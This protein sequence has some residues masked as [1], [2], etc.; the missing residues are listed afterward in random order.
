MGAESPALGRCTRG[1]AN[2]APAAAAVLAEPVAKATATAA[3]SLACCGTRTG[4]GW[5]GWAPGGGQADV[6]APVLC[7]FRALPLAGGGSTS[8]LGGG[9]GA[10]CRVG[11]EAPG[12][13]DG[14][15]GGGAGCGAEGEARGG[16][17]G[18]RAGWVGMEDSK[19]PMPS[20]LIKMGGAKFR[21]GEAALR[22]ALLGTQASRVSKDGKVS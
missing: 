16:G 18:A 21:G 17:G 1:R 19:W 5:A 15:G 10:G 2:V 14:A 7:F 20:K 9:G 13:D 4:A 6:L 8:A 3:A 22:R 12:G 11:G